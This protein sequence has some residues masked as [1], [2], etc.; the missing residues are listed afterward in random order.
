M[1]I[2]DWKVIIM[3]VKSTDKVKEIEEYNEFN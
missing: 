2:V 1:Y 3:V